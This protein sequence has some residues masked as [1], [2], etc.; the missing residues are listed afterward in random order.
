[1]SGGVAIAIRSCRLNSPPRIAIALANSSA[2]VSIIG[3]RKIRN[4][5]RRGGV[6]GTK[7]LPLIGVMARCDFVMELFGCALRLFGAIAVG[8]LDDMVANIGRPGCDLACEA[9]P[10]VGEQSA[11]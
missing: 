10:V 3:A 7:L 2:T 6:G 11:R 1:M 8:E 5:L 4:G 9:P